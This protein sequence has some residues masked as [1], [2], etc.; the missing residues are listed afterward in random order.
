MNRFTKTQSLQQSKKNYCLSGPLLKS[1]SKILFHSWVSATTYIP[2]GHAPS[3]FIWTNLPVDQWGSNQPS[4]GEVF[5]QAMAHPPSVG[6][7]SSK[8]LLKA[9]VSLTIFQL[10]PLEKKNRQPQATNNP[11]G[12]GFIIS[13]TEIIS[14][15]CTLLGKQ[16]LTCLVGFQ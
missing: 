2:L 6:P 11:Y 15:Q 14:H 8:D 9:K 10:E 7:H 13:P 4:T 16:F 3:S 12:F 5:Y 1:K